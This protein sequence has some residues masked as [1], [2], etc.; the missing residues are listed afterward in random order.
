MTLTGNYTLPTSTI[1]GPVNSWRVGKSLGID[2]LYVSSICSF[3]CIYCQLGK[4]N[5]PTLE[6]KVYVPTAKM[7]TDLQAS[8]WQEADVVTFSG[9]GEPTLAANLGEVLRASKALTDKP[10]IV[11]TN[12]T[13][14]NNPTVRN[15]LAAADKIFCKLDAATERTLKLIA[16]SRG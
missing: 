11:L 15:D 13:L 7:M 2:L 9:S 3:R 10:M 16:R 14:L 12:S 1:Y 6:R 8:Q 5:E 4:I